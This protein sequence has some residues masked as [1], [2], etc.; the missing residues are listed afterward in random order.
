M[1]GSTKRQL[2]SWD[3]RFIE[4]ATFIGQWSK[5]RSRKVGCVIVDPRRAVR[6]IG[7]NGFPRGIEDDTPSR[8]DRP[9]KYLWT[10][11]AERNAIYEAARV[12]VSLEG[13][14]MYLPWF[15][16]MDCARAIV[17]AGIRKL[18][19]QRPN[20]NEP[21]WGQHFVAALELLQESNIE[22]VWFE[23]IEE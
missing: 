4:L 11:H 23:A 1:S 6:S 5:D 7:Y 14:T 3:R 18:V 10:E 20:I 2:D 21:Q 22:L 17:Q 12:G 8:H 9:A 15:P 16:C 19:A 13:C